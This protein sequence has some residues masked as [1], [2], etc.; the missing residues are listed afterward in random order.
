MSA[1]TIGPM[2]SFSPRAAFNSAKD[3]FA[4]AK[5][6]VSNFTSGVKSSDLVQRFQSWRNGDGGD[7]VVAVV[8]RRF[9]TFD[10]KD[11][12]TKD[13]INGLLDSICG[14]VYRL[15]KQNSPTHATREQLKGDKLARKYLY[16]LVTKDAY[17]NVFSDATATTIEKMAWSSWC[18]ERLRCLRSDSRNC[19]NLA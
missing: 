5:T 16:A 9:S 10:G 4:T 6:K 13:D 1:V 19:Q 17:R 3:S 12:V 14:S 18:N 15:R 7:D 11:T 8:M 2:P